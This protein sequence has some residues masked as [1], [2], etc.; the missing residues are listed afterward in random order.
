M[1]RPALALLLGALLTG[2]WVYAVV[3]AAEVGVW[4]ILVFLGVTIAVGTVVAARVPANPIGW[5]LLAV[6]A[7]FL[8]Q[9]PVEVIGERLLEITPTLA[10]WLLWFGA[11]RDD[12]WT[13]FPPLWLLFTQVL[14]H[15][16]DGR[17][18][19]P[20]WRRFR[21]FTWIVGAFGTVVLAIIDTEIVPGVTSP[22]GLIANDNILVLLSLVGLLVSALGSAGSLV[23]RYRNATGVV[24]EQITWVTF[25][26]VVVISV[27]AFSLTA[28]VLFATAELPWLWSLVSLSYSLIPL[29]MGI[30]IL[31]Y[32]LWEID[33]ILSRTVSYALVTAVV[34]GV[35][36]LTVTTVA[37]LLP[38]SNTLA[39]ALATLAAAAAFRPLLAWV[40]AR[41]DRR[42]DRA[43]FDAVREVEA[44]ASRLASTVDPDAVTADLLAVLERTLAPEAAAVWV[45]GDR[46]GADRS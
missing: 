14:L 1:S 13:W 32:R 31:R 16:P 24:R 2:L 41:V 20:R 4:A 42:F 17:L 30:A 6:V 5:M 45:A 36:A 27:Y 12:T 44:F 40:Q 11:E 21:L 19:S 8:L 43:R 35:Y 25:A 23:S 7:F 39:V 9:A 22:A 18:P 38:V 34:L 46:S 33:R 26:V 37:R 29:S 15:F 3:T 28:G 10:G